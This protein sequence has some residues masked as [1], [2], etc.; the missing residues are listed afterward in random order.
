MKERQIRIALA[1]VVSVIGRLA[2]RASSGRDPLG[3]AFLSRCHVPEWLMVYAGCLEH[4]PGLPPGDDGGYV[5]LIRTADAIASATIGHSGSG[6]AGGEDPDC[7]FESIYNLLNLDDR[8]DQAARGAKSYYS[9]GT[10]ADG[11]RFPVSMQELKS[12]R[13]HGG[14]E[15]RPL[16]AGVYQEILAGLEESLGKLECSASC[17]SSL[18]E[19]LEDSLTYVPAFCSGSD[20]AD[21]SMYDHLKMS[22]AIALAIDSYIEDSPGS[23]LQSMGS[24]G[25][26][27]SCEEAFLLFSMDLC[28]IQDFIY[29]ISTDR[30]L[31]TLR[32][33]SFYLEL[34]MEHMIDMVLEE[35]SCCRLN[36]I[37]SGGGHCYILLPN[38]KDGRDRLARFCR[39]VNQ[40]LTGTFDISLF[41]SSGSC[42]CS[43]ASLC[44]RP[45]GSFGRIFAEIGDMITRAKNCRYSAAD[46]LRLNSKDLGDYTRECRVCRRAGQLDA[47]GRCPAC[48]QL[49]EF[50]NRIQNGGDFFAV[51]RGT[52][53]RT[54]PLPGNCCLAAFS[55]DE[56]D[57]RTASGG[58]SILR[59][60]AKNSFRSGRHVAT[61]LW[62]GDYFYDRVME[63]LAA[64]ST[65]IR[66]I[67]VLR[68]DVDNL[69][70]TFVRGFE[71]RKYGTRYVNLT[72]TAALSRSMSLF[73]KFHINTILSHSRF[74]LDQ[75]G[76]DHCRRVTIVYS[77][78]DDIFLVGAWNEVAECAA[79][80]SRA[81]REYTQ[82][83]LTVSAGMG[84]YPPSYPVSAAAE[85]TAGYEDASKSRP[86]KNAVTMF[87]DGSCHDEGGTAV[88]DGTF[89]W[90][91]FAEDV[92]GVKYRA[93]SDF[94]CSSPG[95]GNS[96]LYRIL[97]L[98]SA[99]REKISFARLAY[100][101]SRL[102]PPSGA[103][104]AEKN[105]YRAF[106]GNIYRWMGDDRDSRQ[107]RTAIQLYVYMNREMNGD[108][109]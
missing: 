50:S 99:R 68:A 51:L 95:R 1:S 109:E 57:V 60:Y 38:L 63:N 52:E 53:P 30:A 19:L 2:A 24:E 54:L 4:D 46:L 15:C 96:F 58:D 71:S 85:E 90:E 17:L 100:L 37:Y 86:G 91:E 107:L 80:I 108:G 64:G 47:D 98:I 49:E 10:L 12:G 97:G 41:L 48:L 6:G 55:G 76:Q 35:F 34:L 42:P 29:T 88:D 101:L 82:G 72:R 32:S 67:A 23:S 27:F 45:E 18:L 104:A 11:I 20:P 102:E 83:A 3:H 87:S 73:F 105:A 94:F 61:R 56:L 62:V 36:L 69:G 106:A 7:Q 65:G 5:N 44:N 77:G 79:D 16:N 28:G 31:K 78:G 8:K 66:R 70:Q 39:D 22:A 59:I 21:I 84:F 74:A 40:W 26:A 93:L 13:D 103:P 75:D 33:R 9:A 43:P 89:S 92:T 14:R 81:L 25:G